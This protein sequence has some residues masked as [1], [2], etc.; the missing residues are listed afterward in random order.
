EVEDRPLAGALHHIRFGMEGGGSFVVA[1]TRP[2]LLPACVAIVAHPDDQRYQ[3]LVGKHAVTPLFRAP[4]P[5]LA[6][7]RASIEKGTGILM[8]CTFGDATDVECWRQ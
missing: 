7:E 2:E 6:D 5:I 4:M 8:V 3:S 1:T